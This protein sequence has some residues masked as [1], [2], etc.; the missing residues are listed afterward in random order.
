MKSLQH[1]GFTLSLTTEHPTL[2]LTTTLKG[3]FNV[4]DYVYLDRHDILIYAAQL[5]QERIYELSG[6]P[7]DSPPCTLQGFTTTQATKDEL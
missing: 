4:R 6:L 3:Q 1:I 5:I 7:S 2:T